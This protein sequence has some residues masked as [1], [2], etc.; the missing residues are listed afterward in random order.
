MKSRLRVSN[1]I[2]RNDLSFKQA[3]KA[4]VCVPTPPNEVS[5]SGYKFQTISFSL[6]WERGL[7]VILFACGVMGH[8]IESLQGVGR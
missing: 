8:E 7:V 4:E 5:L 3:H 2:P 1:F 6:G